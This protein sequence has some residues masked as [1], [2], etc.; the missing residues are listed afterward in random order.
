MILGSKV[1]G[2]ALRLGGECGDTWTQQG[3]LATVAGIAALQEYVT[4]PNDTE[5]TGAYM[6][7]GAG[8]GGF[9]GR[10]LV[11][12][13][14][15][16]QIADWIGLTGTVMNALMVASDLRKANVRHQLF[17]AEHIKYQMPGMEGLPRALPERL[18]Q[19][20]QAGEVAVIA[21]GSGKLGQS[22]DS[23]VLDHAAALRISLG[24]PVQVFKATSHGGVYDAD[25][26]A[27]AA[28][29]PKPRLLGRVSTAAIRMHR[30]FA[31]DPESVDHLE[32][33]GLSIRLHGLDQTVPEV[34]AGNTGTLIVPDQAVQY[35]YA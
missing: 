9:R 26:G 21:G 27:I 35:A 18:Q 3:R 13:G 23:A 25:P 31:I 5:A 30:W 10:E 34:M 16:A 2:E 7:I 14:V 17:L 15:D 24:E 20:F 28:G 11:Q 4:G 8:N 19:S 1:S 22:S 12:Q 33:Y 32:A 29:G 6:V